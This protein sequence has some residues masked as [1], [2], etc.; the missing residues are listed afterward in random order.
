M[1]S[2]VSDLCFP[3]CQRIGRLSVITGLHDILEKIA[4]VMG[5]AAFPD[6]DAPPR[7]ARIYCFI[8]NVLYTDI[9][10]LEQAARLRRGPV[11]GTS[12]ATT[13]GYSRKHTGAIRQRESCSICWLTGYIR[14]GCW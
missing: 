5:H 2:A 8:V 14:L 6:F 10:Q 1:R 3:V 12:R 7:F 13:G 4:R 11:E 9:A